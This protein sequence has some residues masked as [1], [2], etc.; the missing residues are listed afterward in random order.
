MRTSQTAKAMSQW[1]PREDLR[2][3]LGSWVCPT[4]NSVDVY[5]DPLPDAAGVYHTWLYWDQPPPLLP[6]DRAYYLAVI[7]P[8]I[9]RQLRA[10][11]RGTVLVVTIE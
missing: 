11:Q 8:E 4:G 10:G 6:E 7:R 2:I 1:P 9:I 5:T 3:K